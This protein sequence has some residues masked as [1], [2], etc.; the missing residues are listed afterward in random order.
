MLRPGG[1][2]A[3]G[4]A[5]ETVVDEND[6]AEPPA[7]TPHD[8][9]LPDS[10]R[11]RVHAYSPNLARYLETM[12]SA[13][14]FLDSTWCFRFVNVEAERVLGRGRDLLLGRSLWTLFPALVGGIV[15]TAFRDAVST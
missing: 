12:P 9:E 7:A 8:G 6:L 13:F 1:S 11:P 2:I 15:D 4:R 3:G 10:G 5:W 14:F